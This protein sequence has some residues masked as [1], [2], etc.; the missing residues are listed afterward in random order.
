MLQMS[1]KYGKLL[2]AKSALLMNMNIGCH[3]DKKRLIHSEV[4]SIN[5][6]LQHIHV[7]CHSSVMK[8]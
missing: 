4:H 3:G 8:R 7:S 5:L 2:I 6:I 1:L